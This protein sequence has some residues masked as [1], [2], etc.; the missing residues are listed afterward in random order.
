[1]P[2]YRIDSRLQDEGWQQDT[3]YKVTSDLRLAL[4][5][6][7]RLSRDP[8]YGMS[9]VVDM[10]NNRVVIEFSAGHAPA[11]QWQIDEATRPDTIR[12]I[13]EAMATPPRL[14]I[15][16]IGTAHNV[17]IQQGNIPRMDRPLHIP[18]PEPTLHPQVPESKRELRGIRVRPRRPENS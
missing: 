10:T 12:L 8:F 14:N 13:E 5:H 1:M 16:N 7:E 11:P 17:Q 2:Y 3:E 15:M 4:T 6:A 9:R 18:D